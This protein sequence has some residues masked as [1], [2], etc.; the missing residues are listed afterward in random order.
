MISII[1]SIGE[2]CKQDTLLG[3]LIH[4]S[5]VN[6]H[7]SRDGSRPKKSCSVKYSVRV[8]I[9]YV[10]ICKK[11]FCSLH[12]IGKSRVERIVQKIKNKVPSPTDNRRKHSNRP[13]NLP[14]SICFQINT[15]INSILKRHS[16]YSRSDNDN[17]KYVTRPVYCK[18]V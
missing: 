10:E 15:H 8:G 13:N 4:I 3:G 2:K 7:R 1:N 12:G 18:I 14:A 11:A 5:E 16:H 17:T 6:R 9:N